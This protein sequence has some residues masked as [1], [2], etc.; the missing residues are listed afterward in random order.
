MRRLA[1]LV[2]S[3]I[4]ALGAGG[5]GAPES[6]VSFTFPGS[7]PCPRDAWHLRRALVG[8]TASRMPVAWTRGGTL[9][10]VSFRHEGQGADA[11]AFVGALAEAEHDYCDLPDGVVTPAAMA[12][13]FAN[14]AAAL[15]GGTWDTDGAT[16][17][18]SGAS[19][20]VLSPDMDPDDTSVR[21]MFGAQRHFGFF[22]GSSFNGP[23]GASGG[24]H[25]PSPGTGRV[26]GVYVRATGGGDMRLAL[27]RGP[28]YAADPGPI[29][30]LGQGVAEAVDG[31]ELGV[32]LFAE[33]IAIDAADELWVVVRAE[34]SQGFAL[35]DHTVAE[36]APVGRGDL[37][38]GEQLIWSALSGDPTVAFEG[39]IDL[40]GGG[41]PYP[42]YAFAGII[43]ELAPYAN[44]AIRTWIGARVGATATGVDATDPADMVDET[45]TFRLPIPATIRAGAITHERQ[46]VGTRT[47]GDDLG[48]AYFSEDPDDVGN[49]PHLVAPTLLRNEGA[50]G[51]TSANGYNVRELSSP[52]PLAGVETLGVLFNCGRA[53]G[54][55]ATSLQFLYDE[56]GGPALPSLDHWDDDGRAWS[57]YMDDGAYVLDSEYQTRASNGSTMAHGDPTAAQP[58]P[59]EIDDGDA[60][61]LNARR[62]ASLVHVP[63]VT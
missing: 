45:V 52:L 60:A 15:D 4:A 17:S 19:D 46:A 28:A 44:N 62:G 50:F 35:R 9:Y 30:I 49:F 27:G 6:S 13:A 33:P 21:G 10:A 36:G 2:A 8:G 59:F 38:L 37:P 25:V 47:A 41:G 7:V 18:S 11:S 58:D 48:L 12:A 29:T 61:P 3:Q 40:G 5:G 31:N 39:T 34:A 42:F 51:V 56:N 16:A 26:L 22:D 55:P 24:V 1:H 14:A 63:G 53:G 20:R 32:V 54:A 57:D 23:M 43:Y